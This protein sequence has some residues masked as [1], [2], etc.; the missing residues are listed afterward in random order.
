MYRYRLQIERMQCGKWKY[1]FLF[2]TFDI[3]INS[4][5]IS[6][7]KN[8]VMYNARLKCKFLT[9]SDFTDSWIIMLVE[10]HHKHL[11]SKYCSYISHYQGVFEVKKIINN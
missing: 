4:I 9:W 5:E 3:K 6:T 7:P 8:H 1:N 11:Q 10:E 2:L